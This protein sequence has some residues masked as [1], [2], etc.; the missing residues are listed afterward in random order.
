MPDP[1]RNRDS[2]DLRVVPT[3]DDLARTTADFVVGIVSE[4][5]DAVIALPT[6]STPL[7][8]FG[9]LVRRIRAGEVDFS[10]VRFFCLDEYLGVDADD[11]NSLTGWLFREFFNPAG[12]LPSQVRTV[13]SQSAD[14]GAQAAA[15]ETDLVNA[16]DL[17]LAVLGIGGN[18]HIA[19][20]EPGSPAVSRTRVIDLTPE[21]QAQAAA[22]WE[23]TFPAPAQAMT[24]GV[25]TLLEARAIVLI[26]S[27][28]SKAGILHQALRGPIAADVPAS[29]LRIKPEKLTVI[30]DDDAARDL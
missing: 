15:Y 2:F 5:P 21:S 20:N 27:G 9:E 6:G 28:E 29:L 18:G 4:R 16:G 23:G 25:A 22:Y 17:D 30:I 11:P 8:L 12:I 19:F 14:A 24:I 1:N 3:T 7:G 10:R 13:P 26:A